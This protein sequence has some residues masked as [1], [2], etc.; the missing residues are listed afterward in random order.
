LYLLILLQEITLAPLNITAGNITLYPLILLK[1]TSLE[2][3]NS[4]AGKIKFYLLILLQEK[5]LALVNSTAGNITPYLLIL[6]QETSL[7]P[8][9]SIAGNITMYL[10]ILLQDIS[11]APVNSTAGNTETAHTAVTVI[12]DDSGP[13]KSQYFNSAC[14]ACVYKCTYLHS[15]NHTTKAIVSVFSEFLS[16]R[17]K[18]SKAFKNTSKNKTGNVLITLRPSEPSHHGFY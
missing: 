10:L 7:A 6:L 4:T 5:S 17:Q 2:N 1:E 16:K 12:Q 18:S 9:N 14:Q 3:V 8:V 11:L 15:T 13:Y